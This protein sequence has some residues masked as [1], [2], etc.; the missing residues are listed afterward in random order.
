MNA[1]E[2]SAAERATVD[3]FQIHLP[4]EV[5]QITAHAEF[6]R[7]R[8]APIPEEG[9]QK[10]PDEMIDDLE[11][12]KNGVGRIALVMK[13]A[14]RAV[15][16]ANK[17]ARRAKALALKSSD[18]K[19][20]DLRDADV[21]LLCEQEISDA[22]DAQIALDFAKD[23]ARAVEQTGSMTQ[24]QASLVKAQMSLAGTGREG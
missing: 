7:S 21:A 12:A 17:I 19:S 18:G 3:R 11:W 15:K 13:D 23:V 24:T 5:E 16:E 14:R 1:P 2:L 6:V 20:T 10:T 9:L 22:E 8:L 4:D